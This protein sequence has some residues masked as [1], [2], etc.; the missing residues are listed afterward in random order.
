MEKY[1]GDLET[2][3]FVEELPLALEYGMTKE[4]FWYEDCDLFYAYQ[5]AYIN[6]V[7]KKAH[8]EGLYNFT[9][10]TY[11]LANSFKEKGEKALQFPTEDIYNPFYQKE[12]TS[13]KYINSIDTSKNNNGIYNIKEMISQRRDRK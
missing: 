12:S 9:A 10:F 6:K 11:A 13:K 3:Y 4:E 8:I 7:H 2:Y 1:S 5:K